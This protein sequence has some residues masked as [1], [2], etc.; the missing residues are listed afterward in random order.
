MREAKL[1]T[2]VLQPAAEKAGLGR[3]PWH[4]F[5]HIHSS[6]LNDLRVPVKIA[7]EQL[8]HA[9]ISTTLN[10]YT[11]VVDT[12]HRKAIE[13]VEDRL[14]GGVARSGPKLAAELK[15]APLA[16]TSVN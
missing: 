15:D 4:Q 2:N 14:F 16:S 1:L 10:I 7:Q 13:D 5:R 9:S 11:H 3:V 8:G 6:L 12:S